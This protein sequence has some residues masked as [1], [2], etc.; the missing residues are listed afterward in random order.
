[1]QIRSLNGLRVRLAALILLTMALV[2]GL[3]LYTYLQERKLILSRMDEDLSRIVSSIANDQE[4][5]IDRTRQF[6]MTLTRLTEMQQ[7]D[8]P[9]CAALLTRLIE[10]YPRYS[11]LGVADLAGRVVCSAVPTPPQVRIS[12]EPWFKHTIKSQDFAIGA[13]S[14][15]FEAGAAL[16]IGYPIIGTGGLTQL[17]VFAALD[18][19]PV[20]QLMS[21]VLMPSQVEFMMISQSGTVLNCHPHPEQCLGKSL[22]G[23]HLVQSIFKEGIGAIQAKGL[24]GIPRLYAFTPLSSTVDTGLYVTAGIPLAALYGAANRMLT[25]QFVGLWFVTLVALSLVWFGGSA[26][27]INPLSVMAKTAQRLSEGDMKARTGL[28]HQGGEL[29]R[30]ACAFDGMAETLERRASQLQQYQNQLRSLASQL[31]LAEERE[32]RRIAIDLHDRVG[33]LLAV[34]KINLGRLKQELQ[35]PALVDLANDVSDFMEQAIQETRSLT[36]QISP[37]ILYELGLTSALGHLVEQLQEQHGILGTY[38]DDGQ[39]NAL[40]EDIRI[41][42]FRAAGELLVNVA[43]HAGARRVSVTSHRE[44]DNIIVCIEDDG[45]GFDP[46]MSAFRS[47][48]NHGFGLFSIRERLSHIGGRL[49]IE[50]QPGKGARVTLIAPLKSGDT[51]M[52]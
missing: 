36:F 49:V 34:S 6:L 32:R 22:L 10:E 9:M 47:G 8:T 17:V 15:D 18:L 29:E 27:F 13:F 21:H 38:A 52:G 37:P 14:M 45:I 19:V 12:D 1:M 5:L 31:S 2:S 40:G 51:K 30:L 41:L 33:Q 3:T 26:L 11:N 43:K 48:R 50:S 44:A 7:P 35:D 4:Q 23:S 24:D 46:E 39:A 20:S 16:T 42:L 25:H 28:D